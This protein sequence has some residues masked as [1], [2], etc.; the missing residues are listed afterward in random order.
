MFSVG[1]I[2]PV[3]STRLTEDDKS[4]VPNVRAASGLIAKVRFPVWD[5][6]DF[7]IPSEFSVQ[8][9]QLASPSLT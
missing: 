6:S 4:D 3:I 2:I 8:N 1:G 9:H 5:L 7:V